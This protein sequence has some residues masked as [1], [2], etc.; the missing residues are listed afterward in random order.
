MQQPSGGFARFERGESDV[1]MRR[2]PWTD[3][4]LL[5]FG[6]NEDPAHVRVSALALTH[7][8]RTGFREDDDRVERGIRWLGRVSADE[9]ADRGIE[10][11]ANLADAA[12]AT[13][14]ID[15]PLRAEAER[16]LRGRQREDGSFGD[17]TDTA[18]ALRALLSLSG[19][20]VQS[21][22]AARFLAN[23]VDEL[24]D[25]LEHQPKTG[26]YGFGLSAQ[27]DDPSAAARETSLAL[28]AFA[29]LSARS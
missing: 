15:H 16:R 10:T 23:R 12:V 21:E 2:L 17:M 1:L 9:H 7:L 4:D 6:H 27:L 5:A 26:E 19:R 3:A 28:R 13:C 29:D 22:R 8:G 14:R 24:G 25:A 18:R 11:L 20:C